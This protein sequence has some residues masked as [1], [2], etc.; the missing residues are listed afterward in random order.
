MSI[1]LRVFA[2]VWLFAGWHSLLASRP[3]KRQFGRWFGARQRSGLYRAFY[4]LQSAL[5]LTALLVY[6]RGLPDRELYQVPAPL[7]P[8]LRLGQAAG[9]VF[10]TAA[11]VE[12]GV[13][14]V[15]GLS[16][17]LAWLRGQKKVA[18]EP[19][20][21]GP[22]PDAVRADACGDPEYAAGALRAGGPFRYSRHPLN[23]AP[24]PV[25]WLT[26]HM[27]LKRLAFNLA[28]TVYMV[29]GSLHEEQRL[30]AAYG[31]RYRAYQH[32]G[33]PFYLPWKR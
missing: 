12:I 10:A 14:R 11:A 17:L 13:A 2:A 3:A 31:R 32:S 4:N 18:P 21:Q 22:A 8:L 1:L 9:L 6:L 30:L 15:T 20:A 23:L 28:A 26:P 5:T 7:G 19:E 29:L 24:L 25:F 27:T 33:V 16:P